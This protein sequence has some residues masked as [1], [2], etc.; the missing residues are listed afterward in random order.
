MAAIV[1]EG[2]MRETFLET[3]KAEVAGCVIIKI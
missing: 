3:G 2:F 1:D